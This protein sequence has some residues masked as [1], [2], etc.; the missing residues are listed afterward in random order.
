M[1]RSVRFF[2][3]WVFLP[4]DMLWRLLFLLCTQS[5]ELVLPRKIYTFMCFHATVR[6]NFSDVAC[7]CGEICQQKLSLYHRRIM[8]QQHFWIKHVFLSNQPYK[9]EVTCRWADQSKM[10]KEWIF[11]P[12]SG[13]KEKL[14]QE[15]R[16][17]YFVSPNQNVLD[18]LLKRGK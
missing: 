15:E 4:S 17:L 2:F 5:H 11:F 12:P 9:D 13:H 3:P 8:N 1:P 14:G 7:F 16:Q 6:A 10:H 18:H